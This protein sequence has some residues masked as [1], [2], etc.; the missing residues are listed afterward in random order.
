MPTENTTNNPP[1]KETPVMYTQEQLDAQLHE[2]YQRGQRFG[3][4]SALKQ[5]RSEINDYISD[6]I[7]SI[8]NEQ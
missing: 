5:V 8:K 4:M 6:L 2:A 7:S 3:I 1:E